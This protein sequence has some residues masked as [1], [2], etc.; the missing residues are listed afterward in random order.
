MHEAD[1]PRG[2]C[3]GQH[4]RAGRIDA[5]RRLRLSFGTI[6]R[7]IGRRIDDD[8]RTDGVEQRLD[9]I[10]VGN[11][12]RFP[13]YTA[14]ISAAWR[15]ADQRPADLAAALEQLRRPEEGR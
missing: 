5:E 11:V 1:P 9:R 4:R 12:Q 14:N 10:P 15:P 8:L 7:R 3:P 6:D 13:R 2:R